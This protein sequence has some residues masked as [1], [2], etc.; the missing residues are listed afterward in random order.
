M[1]NVEINSS[2]STVFGA[3]EGGK[4]VGMLGSKKLIED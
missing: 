3:K 2:F 1:E 4:D